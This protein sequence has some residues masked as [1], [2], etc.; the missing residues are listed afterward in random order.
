MRSL[1]EAPRPFIYRPFDQAFNTGMTVVVRTSGDAEATLLDLMAMARRLDPELMIFEA[2][3][4]ERH[5]AVPLLPARLSAVLVSAFGLLAL[6]L[7]S[8]GLFGVVS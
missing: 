7:A 4:M 5:L 1:G 2:K 6:L 8:I 3:T